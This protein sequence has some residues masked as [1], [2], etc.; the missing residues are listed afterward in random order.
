MQRAKQLTV[1]LANEPGAIAGL[2]RCLADAKVNI[3]AITV[4]ESTEAGVV[5]L[6]PDD[7]R[8]AT[9]AL[10]GAGMEVIATTVRLIELPNK[11]GALAEA[12]ERMAKRGMNV[13]FLYGSTGAGRGKAV[14]VVDA[15]KA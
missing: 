10:E 12:A 15:H 9:K 4:V 2:C 5:R 6:V 14:L 11:V 7:A 1:C 8:A 3:R 13:D